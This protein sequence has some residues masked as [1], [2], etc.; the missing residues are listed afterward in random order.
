[1]DQEINCEDFTADFRVDKLCAVL[2]QFK[3]MGHTHLGIAS[4]I[5]QVE[6]M[7]DTRREMATIVAEGEASVGPETVAVDGASAGPETFAKRGT[8]ATL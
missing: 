1:M 6:A 2:S 5:E 7:K 3:A 8:S 4:K